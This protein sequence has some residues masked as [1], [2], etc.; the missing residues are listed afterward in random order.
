MSLKCLVY[1]PMQG[2]ILNELKKPCIT[3]GREKQDCQR[4]AFDW[5]VLLISRCFKPRLLLGQ[6]IFAILAPT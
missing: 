6:T 2:Q 4:V 1:V 3:L 5:I